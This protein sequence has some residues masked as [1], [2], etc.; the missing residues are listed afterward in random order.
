MK[1]LVPKEHL[2]KIVGVA[3]RVGLYV[4]LGVLGMYLFGWGLSALGSY[5]VAAAVGGF[6]AAATANALLMRIFERSHLANIGLAWNACSVRNLLIGLAG[7]TGSAVLVLAGPVVVGLAEF[8][9]VPGADPHWRTLIFVTVV[10]LLGAVG[11][12]MFFRGY[13]FQVL[14]ASA[15]PFATI[16]PTGVLF[17]LAHGSNLGVTKLGLFN[18]MVWGVLLGYAFVRSGDLWLPIGLHVGWNWALPLFGV[19]LSGFTMEVTGYALHW[20]I[21]PVWSGGAYG[22]EGGLITSAVT[23]LL[24]VYLWKAPVRR[25]TPFLLRGSEES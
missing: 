10:L 6:L 13:G 15:G 19:N 17:G 9:A 1:D 22:P 2:A 3:V 8:Q 20:R 4:V 23:V 12:E 24:F 7:G 11:E 25:Q 21:G 5:L 16:L 14:I 18:T